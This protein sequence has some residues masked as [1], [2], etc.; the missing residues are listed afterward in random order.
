MNEQLNQPKGSI[1]KTSITLIALT[2]AALAGNATAATSQATLFD[3]SAMTTPSTIWSTGELGYIQNPH[4]AV[5]T[6]VE[7]PKAVSG[8]NASTDVAAKTSASTIWTF[9]EVGYVQNPNYAAEVSRG[10]IAAITHG[11]A[12]AFQASAKSFK[13]ITTTF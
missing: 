7:A 2:V 8:I 4:G 3:Q 9:G 13:D 6:M 1:M 5:K 12:M 10:G 11:Q